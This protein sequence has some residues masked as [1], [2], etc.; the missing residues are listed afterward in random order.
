MTMPGFSRTSSL[1]RKLLILVMLAAALMLAGCGGRADAAAEAP[2]SATDTPWPTLAPVIPTPSPTLRG[3]NNATGEAGEEATG[4][5]V[6][7]TPEPPTRA[8]TVQV[9]SGPQLV[10]Q[11]R[12]TVAPGTTAVFPLEGKIDHPV[13][14]EVIVLSGNLDPVIVIYNTQGDRLAQ[15]NTA[16]PNQPEVIGQFVFPV[17]G[18]YELGITGGDGEGEVGVSVYRL[19]PADVEG[20]GTFEAI[21]QTLHGVIDHPS[22]YHTFRLPVQRGQR[23]DLGAE[24]L[25]EGLDLQYE[26]YDPTG[27]LV[28]ARDDNVDADPWLWNYMP[29]Q[30]GVYTLVLSNYGETTGQYRV[31]Y[32]ISQSAGEAVL[33]ARTELELQGSPRRSSWLTFEATALDAVSVEVEPLA[34]GVDVMVAL[35]DSNG[36]KIVEVNEGGVGAK[37]VMSLVQFPFDTRYQIEF[38]TNAEGGLVEYYIRYYK[39][40]ELDDEKTGGFIAPGKFGKSGEIEG[41]GSVITYLF[42]A[43]AGT[44]IGI[45]AHATGRGN[46]LD[47]GFDLYA[48]DGT[49]LVRRDD[50]VGKNPVLDGIELAQ[51]G[52]YALTLWN[53][54]GTTGTFDVFVNDLGA[55][56]T[57]PGPPLDLGGE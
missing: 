31:S 19:D 2:P 42:D 26:L 13:R 20:G 24:A 23:F 44:L 36:N 30:S 46:N 12:T 28:A 27:A 5:P 49:R 17:D 52:R 57:P 40:V 50:V 8:T 21:D 47:L 33:G 38:S 43:G 41:P 37:E 6:E 35:Y 34:E 53:Y 10:E 25:T 39:Q 11:F 45:D 3:S 9:S 32:T 29:N 48:P 56:A 1:N 54:G 16:G 51:S 55:P 4:E 22:T 7:G 18:Y 14:I 15:S